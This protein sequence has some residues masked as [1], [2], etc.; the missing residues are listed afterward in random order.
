MRVEQWCGMMFAV[1][2]GLDI[3]KYLGLVWGKFRNHV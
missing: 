2:E 1:I 3:T